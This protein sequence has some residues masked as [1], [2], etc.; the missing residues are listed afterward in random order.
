MSHHSLSWLEQEETPCHIRSGFQSL[1]RGV[2]PQ[3]TA[4]RSF[5]DSRLAGTMHARRVL[6]VLCPLVP[7]I[8]RS[9]VARKPP[10]RAWRYQ[11]GRG[12]RFL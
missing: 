11:E 12:Q 5:S 9:V 3:F 7:L 10:V 6:S 1:R 8:H 2:G 4:R